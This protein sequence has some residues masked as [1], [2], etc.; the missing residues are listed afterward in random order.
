MGAISSC[1]VTAAQA[2]WAPT[3]LRGPLGPHPTSGASAELVSQA[4]GSPVGSAAVSNKNEMRKEIH[5]LRF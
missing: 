1:Q 4:G 2:S 5:K 3:R